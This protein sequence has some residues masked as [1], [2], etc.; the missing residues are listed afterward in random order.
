MTQPTSHTIND[1]L[2]FTQPHDLP[3]AAG[4]LNIKIELPALKVT[5]L[6][7][8]DGKAT[9]ASPTFFMKRK[10]R[11]LVSLPRKHYSPFHHFKDIPTLTD[12]LL[13]A[14]RI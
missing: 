8:R 4:V 2:I 12:S 1:D 11:A 13:L 9:T 14:F 7:E 6:P 10:Q 3:R 5:D